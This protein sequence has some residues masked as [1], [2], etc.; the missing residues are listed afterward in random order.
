MKKIKLKSFILWA[1]LIYTMFTLLILVLCNTDFF[2]VIMFKIAIYN[3]MYCPYV[4]LALA[5]LPIIN[6]IGKKES[7]KEYLLGIIINSVMFAFILSI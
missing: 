6:I 2:P 3:F 1:T 7:I 5:I 4:Y